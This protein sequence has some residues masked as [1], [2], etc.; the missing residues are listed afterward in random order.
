M[1][2]TTSICNWD[3]SRTYIKW[4]CPLPLSNFISWA[5]WSNNLSYICCSMVQADVVERIFALKAIS[6]SICN[7]LNISDN[8][9]F[10][11]PIFSHYSFHSFQISGG[12]VCDHMSISAFHFWSSMKTCI[13][14]FH[15]LKSIYPFFCCQNFT[16]FD[17]GPLGHMLMPGLLFWSPCLM[18]GLVML[19]WK[20]YIDLGLCFLSKRWWYSGEH[21]C[22]PSSWPG[23]DSRPSQMPFGFC[24]LE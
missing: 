24:T 13:I 11:N 17:W 19:Q 6:T 23:F 10:S 2:T 18:H 3:C 15:V 20:F 12:K 5:M 22:L 8:A 1:C 14:W 4:K 7:T 16:A 21:S 9:V